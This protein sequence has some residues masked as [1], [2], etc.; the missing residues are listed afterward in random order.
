MLNEIHPKLP[1]R[2]KAKTKAFYI[3]KL[4]FNQLGSDDFE[5]YLMLKKDSVEIHFFEYKDLNPK[6]NYGMI[7]I[8]TN[9]IKNLYKNLIDNKVDIHPS[10]PLQ[11]KPWGQ[12][13]FSILDPD[14]NLITFGQRI[15]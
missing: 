6:T 9:D 2:Q 7:Y 10:G 4:G 3:D 11:T 1:M 8:R 12:I 5:A 15:L 13:E 14:N